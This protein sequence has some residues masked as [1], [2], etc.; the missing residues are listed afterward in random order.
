[1]SACARSAGHPLMYLD[2]F[3]STPKPDVC[4][5]TLVEHPGCLQQNMEADWW[6]ISM[7]IVVVTALRAVFWGMCLQSTWRLSHVPG[8]V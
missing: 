4:R 7:F 6:F 8:F 3:A 2:P 5:G 1:M